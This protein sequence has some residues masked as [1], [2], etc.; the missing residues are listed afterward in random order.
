MMPEEMPVSPETESEFCA[1]AAPESEVDPAAGA[2]EE[3]AALRAEADA[4]RS[5]LAAQ[6]KL[7]GQLREFSALYPETAAEEIPESVWDAV[8][9]GLPLAAAYALHERRA[10]L[11][12]AEAEAE[13][14]K[15]RIRSSGALEGGGGDLF[16]SPAEVRAMNAAQVRQNYSAILA[17]MQRWQMG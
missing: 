1:A 17:S 12:R 4:L 5:E 15:A 13:Q 8:K 9:G 3:L 11:A 10:M 14:E 16:Y 6:R 7:A 2:A